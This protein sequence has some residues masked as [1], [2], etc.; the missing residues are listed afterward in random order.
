M[1]FPN[2]NIM[3]PIGMRTRL[4]DLIPIPIHYL[5]PHMDIQVYNICYSQVTTHLFTDKVG[6]RLISVIFL[7]P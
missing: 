6:S 2:M 1:P 5:F 4:S 3:N 7:Q